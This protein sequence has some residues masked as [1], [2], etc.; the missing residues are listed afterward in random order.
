VKS[1]QYAPGSLE[2]CNT[3]AMIYRIAGTFDDAIRVL[4]DAVHG[5]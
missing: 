3:E 4:S 1:R 5:A 2:V